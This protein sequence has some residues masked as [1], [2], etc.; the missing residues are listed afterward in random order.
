M[1]EK[2]LEILDKMPPDAILFRKYLHILSVAIDLPLKRDG[3]T[4]VEALQLQFNEKLT[5]LEQVLKWYDNN[6]L[7]RTMAELDIEY[8]LES[9]N[10]NFE[11][12]FG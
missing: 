4:I 8:Y 10:L 9:N 5:P 3:K 11:D 2:I 12:I 6:G 1:Q 7:V